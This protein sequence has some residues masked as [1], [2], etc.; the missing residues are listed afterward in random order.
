MF[1]LDPYRLHKPLANF[2]PVSGIDIYV[3]AVQAFRTVI[4]IS[5]AYDLI[6]AIAANKIFF[7]PLENFHYLVRPEGI[8]PPITV[9]KT[10]V[11]SVSPRTLV[12]VAKHFGISIC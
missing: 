6:A 8:E 3:L 12:A 10:V 11:I 5:G 7:S 2:S 4:C 9:P 1:R